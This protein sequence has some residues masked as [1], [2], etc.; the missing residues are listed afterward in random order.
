[1]D[2]IIKVASNIGL[3]KEQCEAATGGIMSLAKNTLGAENYKKITEKIPEVDELVKKH[4]D[5]SRDATSSGGG[6]LL[7]QAMGML[8]KADSGGTAGT[9][10]GV[11]GLLAML[12]KQ[13]I[14]AKEVNK[15]MP[16][17]ASIVKQQCGVD[18]SSALGLPASSGSTGEGSSEQQSSVPSAD[19]I[20]TSVGNVM[21]GLFGKK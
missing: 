3:S 1:M 13:G 11:A 8:G 15:F 9:A 14:D 6:G 5:G 12:Q 19:D 4:E 20:K 16:Q 17:L 7:G 21:G 2:Q 10:G 18:I